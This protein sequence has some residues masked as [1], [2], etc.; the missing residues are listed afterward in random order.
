[1][2]CL[3]P[4][5]LFPLLETCRW[6]FVKFILQ[7]KFSLSGN[8]EHGKLFHRITTPPAVPTL[9]G[10]SYQSKLRFVACSPVRAQPSI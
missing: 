9:P 5:L 10:V 8:R 2:D 6:D 1:V 7:Q 4:V 3:Q